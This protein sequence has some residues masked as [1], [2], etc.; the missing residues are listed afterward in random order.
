MGADERREVRELAERLT[1]LMP[2]FLKGLMKREDLLCRG[3]ISFPQFVALQYLNLRSPCRMSE[4]AEH[5]SVRMASA[6]GMADRMIR[7][8][9]V[10]R[11]AEP[12]DRRV[13]KI[14]ITPKGKRML[15]TIFEQK[16]RMARE[17]FGH[18]T[19]R[20][21]N[22]YVRILEKMCGL[23]ANREQERERS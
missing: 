16:R 10:R 3:T 2:R 5:L 4:M 9:Y 7:A 13:V 17:L 22:D 14:A 20:E 8:G 6:T 12:K 23:M 21:R 11:L 1:D 18:L 15:G 19:R